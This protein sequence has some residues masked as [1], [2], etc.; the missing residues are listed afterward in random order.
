MRSTSK[1]GETKALNCSVSTRSTG[2]GERERGGEPVASTQH[3][4][5]I[6]TRSHRIVDCAILSW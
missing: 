3:A 4:A 6:V 1:A 2:A 5:T